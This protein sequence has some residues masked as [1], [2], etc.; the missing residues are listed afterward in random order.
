MNRRE[1]LQLLGR[2]GIVVEVGVWRGDFSAEILEH[3]KPKKL[4]LVDQWKHFN[5]PTDDRVTAATQAEMDAMHRRVV[6]RFL[7]RDDVQI[8][9]GSSLSMAEHFRRG[10]GEGKC[11]PFDVVYIDAQHT[12]EAAEKDVRAWWPTVRVGGY[13]SGHDYNDRCGVKRAVDEFVIPLR[14]TGHCGPL[15]KTSE[16]TKSWYVQ[17]LK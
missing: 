5:D 16:P 12:Y 10:I 2:N 6:A 14:A 4:I 15:R 17:R 7:H 13:L 8:A 9:R 11:C 1:L 3:A